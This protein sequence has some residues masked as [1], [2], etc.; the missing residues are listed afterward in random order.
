MNGPI[1]PMDPWAPDVPVV[2][3]VEFI[4]PD[5]PSDGFETASDINTRKVTVTF[6]KDET[7]QD[8]HRV[9]MTL[10]QLAA[11]IGY[12]TAASKMELPWLKLALFGDKRSEKNSLRT[13]A[14]VVQISGVEGDHDDGTLSFD[15]AVAKIRQTKIRAMLYT[16]AS[17]VPGIKERWRILVPLSK[18]REGEAREKF[19]ARVNGLLDGKLAGESFTLSQG[20]LYGHVAGAEYRVEILDGDLLDL[21]DDLYAGS[22]FMNGSKIGG[23]VGN[24]DLNDAG[25]QYKS[26]KDDDPEP[27]DLGKIE[28][29]LNVVSSDGDYKEVWMPIGG[30][31]YYALGDSGFELFDRWSAKAP[32]RYNAGQCRESWRGVRSLRNYTTATIFHFADQADPDWRERYADEEARR[33]FERMGNRA[34]AAA[35]E[36]VA[37]VGSASAQMKTTTIQFD[38]FYAYMLEHKY[39]YAP[40]G[41]V[42]PAASV[43]ARL[44][45][46]GK[47]KASTWLDKNRPVEQMTWVP[48]EPVEIRDRLVVNGGWIE[49]EGSRAFN[50]YRAP[51]LKPTAGNADR[52]VHH[53]ERLYG[54]DA[55]HIV[56][57]CAHRVQK[58][59]DKINH[60]LVLGGKQGIGKDTLLEAVK[61]AIGAWNFNEV[62]PQQILGRFNGFLKSVV[63]RVSEARDL[64]EFDRFAFY[65]HMK[66]ITA[67]P[68]DVLRIDEKNRQEYAIPNVCGVIITTNHKSDGIY[69]PA[70]DRRHFVAWSDLDKSAFDAAHWD[71][72]YKW[73]AEGGFDVIANYL[74]NLDLTGFNPKAPPPQTSAFF[75]IVNSSRTP[76][77]AEFADALD[78]LAWPDAVTI[79]AIIDATTRSDF[80]DYLKDRRNSRRIPHRFEACGYTTVRNPHTEDGLWRPHGRRQVIYARSTLDLRRRVAAASA[81]EAG[82][83]RQEWK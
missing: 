7:G 83:S 82:K 81:I 44:P 74:Q 2:E 18:A 10:P 63:L 80:I 4:P 1:Q 51:V 78:V 46:V 54:E 62:S 77:D 26:R 13:N 36:G 33:F 61:H 49:R 64:G 23:R 15:D 50:L 29:A 11:H 59:A 5:D 21:R 24:I 28:A 27:V 31:L 53:V 56:R 17:H 34:S 75:E 14:N 70:D 3:G 58:P 37:E 42:W 22:I 47:L 76:E 68:P 6:I 60:A 67:A 19:L 73:Y 43:D 72:L 9:D 41:A 52:W 66:A 69:L 38:D 71:G 65:D 30:A 35:A 45:A 32:A 8:M 57:W 55:A 25:P 16:S 48:G 39:I 79:A 12:Q 40:L 20:Y